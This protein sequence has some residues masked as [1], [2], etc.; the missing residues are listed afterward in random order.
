MSNRQ[1]SAAR[2][3]A[4]LQKAERPEEKARALVELQTYLEEQAEAETSRPPQEVAQQLT[5]RFQS[6]SKPC[7]FSPGQLVKWKAD[8]KNRRRPHDGEPAI[9]VAH[10]ET[11]ILRDEHDSGSSYFREPLDLVLGIL[12]S[13]GD[14]LCY[15]YDS[16]RFEAF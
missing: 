10:L 2:L 14:F 16:R 4:L 11:P 1:S 7:R 9:V 8:L 13:D 3:L 5:K 12:D 6:L 15:H